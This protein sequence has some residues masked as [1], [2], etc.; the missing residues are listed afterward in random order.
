MG[1]RALNICTK[2]GFR[3]CD[4]VY[5]IVRRREQEE[6]NG[7]AS[8]ADREPYFI[9]EAGPDLAEGED[10]EDLFS[11]KANPIAR[12]GC[13]ATGQAKHLITWLPKEGRANNAQIAQTS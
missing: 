6:R 12:R 9:S 11:I 5:G 1:E 13:K 8:P 7:R 2:Y 10:G 3:Q 4:R